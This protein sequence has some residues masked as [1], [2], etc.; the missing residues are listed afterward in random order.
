M[1][2]DLTVRTPALRV[3]TDVAGEAARRDNRRPMIRTNIIAS[4]DEASH[5]KRNAR[6]TAGLPIG[7]ELVLNLLLDG[8]GATFTQ[9]ERARRHIVKLQLLFSV[10]VVVEDDPIFSTSLS[11]LMATFVTQIEAECLF[12]LLNVDCGGGAKGINQKLVGGLP[13]V[14][15]ALRRLYVRPAPVARCRGGG[16]LT[17][18]RCK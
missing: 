17:R 10:Q 7:S 18:C 4:A 9:H 5:N 6:I 8:G 16:G 3:L 13:T 14:G 2:R 15:Y 12:A 1:T 11:L